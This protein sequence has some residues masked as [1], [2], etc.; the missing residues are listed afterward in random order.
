MSKEEEELIL[1]YMDKVNKLVFDTSTD[2][3]E[4]LAYFK[5][6]NSAEMTLQQLKQAV[7]ILEKK[8]SKNKEEV[9]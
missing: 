6:K 2:F 9:F 1:I 3:D 5:V 8:K 4:L 7:A